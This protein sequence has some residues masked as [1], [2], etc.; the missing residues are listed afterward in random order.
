MSLSLWIRCLGSSL[1]EVCINVILNIIQEIYLKLNFRWEP[2]PATFRAIAPKCCPERMRC[3]ENGTCTYKDQ[4]I[5]N[6]AEIPSEL[7]GCEQHCFCDN[8]KVEC[9]PACP[10]VP[11]LPPSTLRCLPKFAKLVALEDSE[12]CK[13]WVCSN[14]EMTG[15]FYF[16]G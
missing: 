5:D 10:P 3:V 12:C 4:A 1:F 14:S 8:G 15:K 11:A 2:E 13:E 7:S 9:R 16:S 6:W